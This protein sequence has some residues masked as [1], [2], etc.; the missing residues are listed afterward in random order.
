M[1]ISNHGWKQTAL[2]G[3]RYT[4]ILGVVTF[5]ASLRAQFVRPI[6]SATKVAGTSIRGFN[7]DFGTASSVELNVPASNLFD[8]DGNQYISDA[9]NNC[10]RKVDAAGNITMV[11]GLIKSG[12]G[13]TCNSSLN[14]SPTAA[15]GLLAPTALALDSRNNLYI[16]DTGHNCVRKLGSGAVGTT[17]MVTVVGDCTLPA[18]ASIVP[19]PKGLALDAAGNLYVSTQDAVSLVNQVVLHLGSDS[20]TTVCRV[21]GAASALVPTACGGGAVP[22][23]S[24]PSGLAFDPE[25]DLFIADTGNGCVREMFL[26]GAFNT[27][28]GLCT[29]DV[30]GSSSPLLSPTGLA[31]SQTGKLLI[32]DTTTSNVYEFAMPATLNLIAGLGTGA[33]GTYTA[34]QDGAPAITVPLSS[35]QGVAVDPSGNVLVVDSQNNIVRKLSAGLRFPSTAVK[36]GSPSQTAFF[37]ITGPVKLT[38]TVGSDYTI[39]SSTCIGS[40][41]ASI[42]STPT[43]CGVTVKFQPTYPG[44]RRS[45]LTLSDAT[46]GGTKFAWGLN[47]IGMGAAAIFPPGTI[48]TLLSSLTNP[49]AVRLNTK[50]DIYLAESGTSGDGDVKVIPAG[51]TTPIPL[52]AAGAG[53]TTPSAL[54]LDSA[55]NLYIADRGTNKIYEYDANGTLTTFASGLS[56]PEALTIDSFDNLYIAEA[57]ASPAVLE[58]FVGGHQMVIAGQGPTPD[59]TGVPATEAKLEAPSGLA[60]N[61][62]GVLY[63]SDSTGHRVY[64]I[65]TGRTIHY[66]VGNGST[67]DTVPGTALGTALIDP[68]DLA[69]DAAGDVYIADGTGNQSIVV[70]SSSQQNSTVSTIAGTGIAGSTGDGGPSNVALLNNPISMALDGKSNIYIVDAG[71]Q[72]LRKIVYGPAM[73]KFGTIMVGDVTPAQTVT[74]WDTG[75]VD[76][77]QV[78]S[79]LLSDP[80]NFSLD[81]TSTLCGTTVLSGATCNYGFHFNP[82]TSGSLTATAI[83]TD[84]SYDSTQVITLTG[85]ATLPHTVPSTI[86]TNTTVYMGVYGTPYNWTAG[87]TGDGTHLPTGTLTFTVNG[88]TVCPPLTLDGSAQVSCSP[89]PIRLAAGT[90]PLSISYSGDNVYA[91]NSV[92]T[93]ATITPAPATIIAN[94]ASRGYGQLN[95]AFTGSITGAVAGE[96]I[97]ATYLTTATQFSAPGNYPIT[98]V[99]AAGPGTSL[100][101]YAITLVNGTL[102]ITQA[103]PLSV[104]VANATRIYGVPNPAF[105]SSIL[106]AV[107]GDTIT[108]TYSTTATLNSP[109]GAYAITAALSGAAVGNYS[110]ATIVPGVL[111]VTQAP[112]SLALTIS[113]NSPTSGTAVTFTAL[114]TSPSQLTPDGGVIFADGVTLLGTGTLDATGHATFT[115]SALT[116]GSHTIAATYPGSVDFMASTASM[117]QGVA[118]PGSNGSFSL[119]VTPAYQEIKGGGKSVYQVTV[120]SLNGFYGPVTLTCAGLPADAGCAFSPATVTLTA[121]AS[122]TTQLNTTTTFKDGL[123]AGVTV[124][125]PGGQGM[126]PLLAWTMFPMQ[127][128]GAATLLAGG[129]RRR[130]KENF[131]KRVMFLLPLTLLVLGLSGCGSAAQFHTYTIAIS[132]AAT[133]GGAPL[134]ETATVT[135]TVIQ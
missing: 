49:A 74:L 84:N 50:G 7:N 75:N 116:S 2:T 37:V 29:N 58:M 107:D 92:T 18:A 25:G 14:S 61:N 71:K 45:P 56:D 54:A 85:I 5:G 69:V 102:T 33:S 47:G 131:W 128:S 30:T 89:S 90:Y 77:T 59:A 66:L 42:T 43:T 3:L 125:V 109:V 135:L 82:L 83:L 119:T 19:N 16:A 32:T 91:T 40:L 97:T 96:T 27:A 115:T 15:Q 11:A 9:G 65:D 112:T 133:S 122:V 17:N 38:S 120:K 72:A 121:G 134:T 22:D 13:D 10:V 39:A 53:L 35:P 94:N 87:V 106:N 78:S 79:L 114:V 55:G 103:G 12:S 86:T 110:G 26:G 62:H 34:S 132:G 21:A 113:N 31:F 108:V 57:G 4:A 118:A 98:P 95:P 41:K 111:S 67:V 101:N 80:T 73:M 127:L 100:S 28:V 129:L 52:I 76:L 23:L 44:P 64:S 36:N 70:Y 8:S 46:S 130:K 51:S 93:T 60:M 105:G 104:T 126:F 24:K 48:S 123:F 81:S 88:T 99:A 20:A 6:P 1:S 117:S 68:R 63:V 124:P